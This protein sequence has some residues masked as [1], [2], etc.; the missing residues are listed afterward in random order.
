MFKNKKSQ[1]AVTDLLIASVVLIILILLLIFW[2]NRYTEVLSEESAYQ[3]K[4]IILFQTA[5]LLIKSQG[6]PQNWEENPN[7]VKVIGLASSDRDI[8]EDKVIAFVNLSYN[9]TSKSL[10]LDLYDFYFQ[11]KSVNGTKLFEHGKDPTDE[12]I[13]IQR[14]VLYKNEK[15]I[16]ELSIWE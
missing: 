3:K 5:D 8:S 4:Q 15:A 2:W 16:I 9:V 7:E 12:V 13:N 1:L 6:L 14:I 11:L 10:G